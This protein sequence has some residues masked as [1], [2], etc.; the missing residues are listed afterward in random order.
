MSI[1]L[2][3]CVIFAVFFVIHTIFLMYHIIHF[4]VYPGQS[5]LIAGAVAAVSVVLLLFAVIVLLR[6]NWN[7]PFT[8][9]TG[10]VL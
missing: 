1:L 3:L 7:A 9:P 4:A 6:I 2:I 8:V 10:G 5:K